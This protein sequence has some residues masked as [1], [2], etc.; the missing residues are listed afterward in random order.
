METSTTA[1]AAAASTTDNSTL[2]VTRNSSNMVVAIAVGVSVGV[3]VLTV[4]MLIGLIK[5]FRH[6]FH[7][8]KGVSVECHIIT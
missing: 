1:E 7:N 6:I 2:D 8:I 5:G 4:I 3:A